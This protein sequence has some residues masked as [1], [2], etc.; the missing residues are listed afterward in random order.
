MLSIKLMHIFQRPGFVMSVIEIGHIGREKSPNQDASSVG[1]LEKKIT[2]AQLIRRMPSVSLQGNHLA[3][4]YPII[5]Y[6]KTILG[7]VE[8]DNIPLVEARKIVASNSFPPPSSH[9]MLLDFKNFSYLRNTF[10]AK[11]L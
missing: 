3:T 6:Q 2:L 1:S 8:Q 7:L 9:N 5:I 10:S 4:S 11:I